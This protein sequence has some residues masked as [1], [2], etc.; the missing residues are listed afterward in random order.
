MEKIRTGPS[1]SSLKSVSLDIFVESFEMGTIKLGKP[2]STP[3]PTRKSPLPH[4]LARLRHVFSKL[5]VISYS[6]LVHVIRLIL[7]TVDSYAL[8]VLFS[9]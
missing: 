2:E 7:E 4:R 1:S 8:F 9:Q 6:R 3:H 5:S